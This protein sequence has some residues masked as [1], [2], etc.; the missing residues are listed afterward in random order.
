MYTLIAFAS[1]YGTS[2]QVAQWLTEHLPHETKQLDVTAGEPVEWAE[3]EQVIIGS[4]IRMGEIQDEMKR[5]LVT[6]EAELLKRPLALYL[7]AGTP[8]ETERR[9]ELERAYAPILRDH[10]YFHEIVGKGYDVSRMGFL[11][12]SIVRLM[13]HDAKTML[14][15][16]EQQLNRLVQ[17]SSSN[18]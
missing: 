5:W 17:A 14:Q 15:L 3:V 16:D 8:S 11:D 12:Q 4:S 9:R 7:C 10:A 2:E 13:T 6:Y 18:S 1:R